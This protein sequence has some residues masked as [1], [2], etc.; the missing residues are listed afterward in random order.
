[1]EHFKNNPLIISK[2]KNII[3]K[4]YFINFFY[5]ILPDEILNRI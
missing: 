1:M 5:L 4:V 3:Q 2:L